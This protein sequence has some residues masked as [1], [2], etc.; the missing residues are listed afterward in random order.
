MLYPGSR[1]Q[2]GRFAWLVVAL[3]AGTGAAAGGPLEEGSSTPISGVW[4]AVPG[5]LAQLG[6]STGA[7]LCGPSSMAP[8]GSPGLAEGGLR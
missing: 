2:D 6:L 5:G 7:P 4:A 1:A 3:M 8:G